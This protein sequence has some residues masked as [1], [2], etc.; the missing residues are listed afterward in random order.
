[1]K[2]LRSYTFTWQQIAIFKLALIALGIAIGTYWHTFFASIITI[3]VV[4]GVIAAVYI[5]FVSFFKKEHKG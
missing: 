2:I 3:L 4:I 1:M 5:L